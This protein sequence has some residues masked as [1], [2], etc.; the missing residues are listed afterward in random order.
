MCGAGIKLLST[1]WNRCWQPERETADNRG[2][3][4]HGEEVAAVVVTGQVY[5]WPAPT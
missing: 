4:G 1:V 5:L 2:G 3:R